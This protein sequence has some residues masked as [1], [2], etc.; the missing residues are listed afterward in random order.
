MPWQPLIASDC[1][2][3]RGYDARDM[4]TWHNQ[5]DDG[6]GGLDVLTRYN[7]TAM[8]SLSFYHNYQRRKMLVNVM[9][10]D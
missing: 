1:T 9:H 5:E 7:S 3:L 2:L 6:H 10:S 4:L 8:V